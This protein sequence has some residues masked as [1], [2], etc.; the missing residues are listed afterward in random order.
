M[1]NVDSLTTNYR[2]VYCII[3]NRITI[4]TNKLL[5]LLGANEQFKN[6]KTSLDSCDRF[7]HFFSNN[8]VCVRHLCIAD[9]IPEIDSLKRRKDPFGLRGSETSVYNHNTTASFVL[10]ARQG[11][12]GRECVVEHSCLP[13]SSSEAES[14]KDGFPASPSGH[15]PV[16]PKDT[17]CQAHHRLVTKLRKNLETV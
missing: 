14:S 4:P 3:I 11:I 9:K 12:L 15:T 5:L 1:K 17:T 6:R 16:T 2:C 7:V 8:N 10:M 13:H